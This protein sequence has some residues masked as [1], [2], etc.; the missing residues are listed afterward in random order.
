VERM[1]EGDISNGLRIGWLYLV[2]P[3]ILG[4][5]CSIGLDVVR[6]ETSTPAVL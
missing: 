1:G 5:V 3:A 2:R 4:S 6:R